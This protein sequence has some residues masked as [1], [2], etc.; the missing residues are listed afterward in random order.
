MKSDGEASCGRRR[1]HLVI[2]KSVDVSP[3]LA[4]A[5]FGCGNN[6]GAEKGKWQFELNAR[7]DEAKHFLQHLEDKE[8]L[9]ANCK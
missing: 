4:I 7:H 3:P 6:Q 1:A 5:R 9:K 2:R 8:K